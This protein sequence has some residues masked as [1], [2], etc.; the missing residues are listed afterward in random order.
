MTEFHPPT[1]QQ[2]APPA[3]EQAGEKLL[4][5]T[6]RFNPTVG[7][8]VRNPLHATGTSPRQ[9]TSTDPDTRTLAEGHPM[10]TAPVSTNP[11][12]NATIV[13]AWP[14]R[15]RLMLQI[16]LHDTGQTEV[17]RCQAGDEQFGAVSAALTD[18]GEDLREDAELGCGD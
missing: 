6:R 15:G 4:A 17:I 9:S 16:W 13:R 3:I 2:V 14:Q 12:R 10:M 7:E 1:D 8:R 18:C 5:K 11:V